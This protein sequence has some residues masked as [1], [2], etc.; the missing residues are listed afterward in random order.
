MIKIGKGFFLAFFLQLFLL[1]GLAQ[2]QEESR[3]QRILQALEQ[4]SFEEADNPSDD[5]ADSELP[6]EF[7]G[8]EIRGQYS[9]GVASHYYDPDELTKI[10]N[11]LILSG[12]GNVSEDLSFR[13][14]GRG[15]YDAVYD[16]TDR[17]SGSAESDQQWEVEL[18]DTYFDYSF[19]PFDAR[20]GKQQ[21][22]WGE[23]VGLFMADVVNAKDL[24]EHVLP[25]F[26]Q[27]R[28]PEWGMDLEYSRDAFHSEFVF[29]PV[30]EFN[31]FGVAGSEFVP[32]LPL[33][34]ATFATY[35]DPKEP[36]DGFENSKLGARFS[37]LLNGLDLGVF[38]LYGWTPS[39][40]LYRTINSGVY[41]F[42]PQY[43]RLHTAGA[44]FSKEINDTIIKGEFVFNNNN[45]FSVIDPTDS[46]GV[47]RSNT[48]DYLIGVDHTFLEKIEFN[49][50]FLQSYIFDFEDT[51]YAQE[52]VSNSITVRFARAFLNHKLETEFLAMAGLRAPDF[53][54]RPRVKYNV[55]DHCQV[56]VGADIFSGQSSGFFG[57]YRDQSRIYM[58]TVLKF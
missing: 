21:I 14:S 42:D 27:I 3:T 49:L 55:N 54:Y 40:V 37:Y 12:T 15:Y 10:K 48:L 56:S 30:P 36:K 1:V 35:H 2:A 9:L 24:R 20:I 22:V 41:E 28:I 52:R 34:A 16:A 5:L 29:L 26:D 43:E 39:A 57:Y 47:A 18:R 13:V 32:P 50:Q 6:L 8:M 46:D 45:Y 23:A 33:P 44:T 51:Y 31:K 7:L 11:Q 17:Y 58:E 4:A 25:D 38:Y 53:L 19:G